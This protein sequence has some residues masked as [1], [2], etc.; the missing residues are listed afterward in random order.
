MY[1]KGSKALLNIKHVLNIV[2]DLGHIIIFLQKI[3][4][5]LYTG[6]GHIIRIS[7]KS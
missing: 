4:S 7:S 6:A 1:L 2:K 3:L 5:T